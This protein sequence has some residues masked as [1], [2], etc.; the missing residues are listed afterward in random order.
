MDGKMGGENGRG[1]FPVPVKLEGKIE[2][3]NGRGHFPVLLK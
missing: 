1:C 3:G 2:G